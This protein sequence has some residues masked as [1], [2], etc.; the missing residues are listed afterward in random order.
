MQLRLNKR[1]LQISQEVTD[2]LPC[3]LGSKCRDLV[4][5]STNGN[6]CQPIVVDRPSSNL[7]VQEEMNIT[8]RYKLVLIRVKT[9]FLGAYD[10]F[11]EIY[12]A[13]CSRVRC[14]ILIIQSCDEGKKK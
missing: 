4:P 14:R 5:S 13:T 9:Q 7:H 10:S 8:G 3:L 1:Q 2:E 6:K 11:N 12:G